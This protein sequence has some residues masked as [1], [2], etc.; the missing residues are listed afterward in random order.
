MTQRPTKAFTRFRMTCG[1][2]PMRRPYSLE[3]A[4]PSD[5]SSLVSSML[6]FLVFLED[7]L[8]VLTGVCSGAPPELGVSSPPAATS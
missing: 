1:A 3:L 5:S 4:S 7:F 2:L 6:D 8:E